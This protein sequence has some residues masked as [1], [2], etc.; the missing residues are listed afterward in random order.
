[1][2]KKRVKKFIYDGLGFPLILVD[3][4]MV[5]IMGVWTPD[6]EYNK[7]QKIVLLALCHK[8]F[9][10]TGNEV[11]FIR[12]YF[13][14][15]LVMFGKHFGVT[16]VAV[17]HWEKSKNKPAKIQPAAE[18]YVR[19]FILEKLNMNNQVFRETFREFD[20]QKI[21]REQK[22]IP[23]PLFLPTTHIKKSSLRI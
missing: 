2:E 20:I 16:H 10:L 19:L 17:L 18:L 7:L 11:R 3:I 14:M 21:T 13:E 23:K 8:P 1:M 12:N 6:I 22:A 9:P 4:Q 15:T 5:K